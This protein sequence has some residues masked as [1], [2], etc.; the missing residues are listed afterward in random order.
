VLVVL[1]LFD[2]PEVILGFDS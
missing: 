2:L 1:E